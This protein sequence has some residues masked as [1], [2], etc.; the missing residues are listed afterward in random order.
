MKARVIHVTADQV[1]RAVIAA[2]WVYGDDPVV[3]M[4]GDAYGARRA[5]TAAASG[6]ARALDLPM[7]RA[8]L[9]LGLGKGVVQTARVRQRPGFD[10][11]EKMAEVAVRFG[12]GADALAHARGKARAASVPKPAVRSAGAVRREV[13]VCLGEDPSTAPDLAQLVGVAEAQ[14]REALSFLKDEGRVAASAMTQ[15]GW[16]AQTWRVAG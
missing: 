3:A 7:M 8:G 10:G 14:I 5:L 13:L 11:A 4:T 6:L 15:E 1:A 9:L 12:L 16:R 2:A